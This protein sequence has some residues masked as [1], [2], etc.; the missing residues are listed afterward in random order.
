MLAG[1]LAGWLEPFMNSFK[2]SLKTSRNGTIAV[3]VLE[4]IR[5]L[6]LFVTK[7][8]VSFLLLRKSLLVKIYSSKREEAVSVYR[9][10]MG[11]SPLAA[12]ARHSQYLVT[13]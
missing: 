5:C 7:S 9:F 13:R 6:L 1:W 4:V 12:A 3:T 10:L 8:R 11:E 2:A